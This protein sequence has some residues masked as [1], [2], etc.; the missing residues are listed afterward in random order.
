MFQAANKQ[1]GARADTLDAIGSLYA[2]LRNWDEARPQFELALTTDSSY[3]LARIHLGIVLL[4]QR[5]YPAAL[6]SLEKAVKQEPA[7]ALAQFEYGRTLE[8]V[9][10]DG[11]AVPYLQ[12]AVRLIRVRR[13][14]K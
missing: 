4:Q 9:D 5:D 8:A 12:E 14:A 3:V 10:Q 6:S 13:R 2:Q 11:A 1:G 7:N